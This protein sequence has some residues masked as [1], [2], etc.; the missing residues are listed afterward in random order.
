MTLLT[1]H[2]AAYDNCP[3][4]HLRS[5]RLGTFD[6]QPSD[7]TA[8]HFLCGDQSD[9]LDVR[10]RLQNLGTVRLKPT[11]YLPTFRLCDYNQIITTTNQPR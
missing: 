8:A 9:D 11:A 1:L 10:P 6:Q 4:T 7:A 3:G 5:P 2:I